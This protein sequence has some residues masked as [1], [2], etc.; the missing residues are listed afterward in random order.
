MTQ[1]RDRFVQCASPAGLHRFAQ[2]LLRRDRRVVLFVN[3]EA[4]P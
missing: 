4:Q 2:G 3:P 1:P